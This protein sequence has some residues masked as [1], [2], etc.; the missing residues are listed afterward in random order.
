[1]PQALLPLVP[2]GASSINDRISVVRENGQWTYFCGVDSVFRHPEEDRL[3]FRMFTAQLVCQGAC[4]Q[5]DIVRAFGVSANSVKRSVKKYREEGVAGFYRPQKRRGATVLV[6]DVL[7]QAQDMLSRGSSRRDVADQLGVRYDTIRKAINHGRLREPAPG[8]TPDPPKKTC[9]K[10]QR[11]VKDAAAEMGV[12]CTRPEERVLAAIGMLQGAPTQFENCRDVSFGGV[13]CALP[14]LVANGLFE[15]LEK[16]FPSLS[17]YYT[18]LQVVTLLAYMALCRIKTVE[19]LQY[20]APGELGKLMGLDRVPE[21]RCLRKKLARL[22]QDDAPDKWA[23]LLSRQWLQAPSEHAGSLYVDGHVR[24]YHGKQ[25]KLPR[26]YVSRQRLCLRGTTDYWVND[27]LGLPFFS[28]ERP[29]DHGMLEALRSDIVPRLLQ[30]VPHQPSGEELEADPCRCRFVIIF[31]R[32]GYSPVFFKEMWQTHRIACITYHKHPKETWP[33][34]EF[35][36]TQVTL[37]RGES[38]VSMKLAERGSWIGDK[39]NGL[40]VREVRKLTGS[41]H[42]VS[43]ISSVYGQSAPEDAARLFSRW[44]QENFFRYMMQHYAIDLLS[45]YQTEEIP[46]TTRPVVNPRWRELDG[47]IRSLTGKLQRCRAEFGAHTIHSESDEEA[48]P[49][50]ELRKSELAEAVEQTDH[51]LQKL[52]QHRKA[53]PHHVEWGEFPAED[54]FE[55]LSPSRKRLTDTVKLIAYRA[56]TAL[57]NIVRETLARPDDA[58][59]L[60]RDLF[61]SEADLSVDTQAGTL[62]IGVHPMANPRSNR[63]IEHLLAELNTTEMRY[64][65]TSLKLVYTLVGVSSN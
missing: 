7:A 17:G 18:T 64:P 33:E 10:S 21:V 59:S 13:L 62:T 48:M 3:S 63:A 32:E 25:T 60:L 43:L 20:A 4:K 51:E 16:I 1:M 27:A 56:E 12:A 26:R 35:S 40:W 50:W 14:A 36:N 52:K 28:V 15:H 30:D 29:I 47:R 37:P 42:Q 39:K 19:Q 58:R 22:S 57:S 2:D 38:V 55:R 45:E 9:D 65:G 23:G 44:S 8:E 61:R 41:G 5:T 34:E 49:K 46:G 54:K 53:V 6:D 11:S 31:D 24:L